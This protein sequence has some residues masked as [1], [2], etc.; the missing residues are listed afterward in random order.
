M[1]ESCEMQDG[2][3]QKMADGPHADIPHFPCLGSQ[4]ACEGDPAAELVKWA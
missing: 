4:G 2:L 1:V 3:S